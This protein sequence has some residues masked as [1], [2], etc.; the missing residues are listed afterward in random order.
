ME[1]RDSGQVRRVART[2]WAVTYRGIL[3]ERVQTT[4][5]SRAYSDD[6]LRSRMTDGLLLVAERVGG[7]VGFANFFR[8]DRSVAELAAIYVLPEM[9]GRG[10]GSQL[11]EAGV[12]ALPEIE[13]LRL[14]VERDNLAAR[15]FYEARGFMVIGEQIERFAGHALHTVVMDLTF[16]R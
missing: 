4:F 2:T 8:S 15:R 12:A 1:P 6:A 7:I 9:Q 11:F 13:R 16:R 3:P 10:I 5:L 14:S